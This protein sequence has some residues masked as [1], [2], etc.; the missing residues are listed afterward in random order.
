M[1][2]RVEFVTMAQFQMM[3]R[4]AKN[5]GNNTW[6]KEGWYYRLTSQTS[7]GRVRIVLT[8]GSCVC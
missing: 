3:I 4:G 2:Q 7:D 1:A 6:W 8:A 5:M